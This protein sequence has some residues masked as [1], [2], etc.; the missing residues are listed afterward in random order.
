MKLV[1]MSVYNQYNNAL[2]IY[3]LYV[4]VCQPYKCS[5]F[6]LSY[7]LSFSLFKLNIIKLWYAV[8]LLCTIICAPFPCSLNAP[9]AY[10]IPILRS[11]S[12]H[13]LYKQEITTWQTIRTCTANLV[14]FTWLQISWHIPTDFLF[15]IFEHVFFCLDITE[16]G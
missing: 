15:I 1:V 11:L 16:F 10:L 12:I 5:H 14:V 7:N 4:C 2:S 6:I 3:F 9:K 8:I 13:P